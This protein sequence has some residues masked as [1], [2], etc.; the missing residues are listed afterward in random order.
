M[1][2]TS[3]IAWSQRGYRTAILRWSLG[4]FC[5]VVG[6]LMLI[7][8]HQFLGPLFATLR[9][10]LIAW[11]V[12]YFTAGSTLVA[13]VALGIRGPLP[14][15]AGVTSAAGLLLL[16]LTFLLSGGMIGVGVYSAF[17][18]TAL[19]SLWIGDGRGR[20]GERP[21]EMF[22]V[23]AAVVAL[24]VG[25]LLLVT[26][27]VWTYAA[28]MPARIFLVSYGGFFLSLGLAALIAE[29]GPP[30]A[31]AWRTPTLIALG[32][33]YLL[34]TVLSPFMARIWTGVA[35][36]GGIGWL[37]IILSWLEAALPRVVSGSL[38]VRLSL[39]MAS[40]AA[41]PLLFVATVATGWEE[42]AAAEQ[43][44]TLQ[45][46][47][48]SGLAADMSG[49]LTQHLVGLTLV[50]EHPVV[51]ERPSTSPE[52][53]LGDVEDVAPGLVTLG[54]FNRA[55]QPSAVLGVRTEEAR[56]RVQRMASEGLRRVPTRQSPSAAF[57][58]DPPDP[59]IV[60]AV[61]IRPPEGG[62]EGVA[63]GQLDRA[64]LKARLENGVAESAVG[65]VVV[66]ERGRAV[67]A[68]GGPINEDDDLS[69]RPSF[70]ALQTA[71]AA[72]GI[73]R[74]NFGAN[75]YL[76]AYARIPET[77]WAVV[78][79]QPTATA[80]ASVWSAREL[81]FVVLLGAFAAAAI[82]GVVLADRLGAPLA[83]L[84]RAAQAFAVGAPG[85]VLPTSR[86]FEVNVLARAFAEMQSR[87]TAR[88]AERER[89]QSRLRVLADAG[90]ELTRSLDEEEIVR[91]LGRVVVRELADWCTVDV[92]YAD[93]QIRSALVLHS[94]PLLQPLADQLASCPISLNHAPTVVKRAIVAGEPV[95]IPE[96]GQD[97]LTGLADGPERAV[98][99]QAL[100]L[101][102]LILV[103]LRVRE[104]TLGMLGCAIARGSRRY[105][106]DD[107]ALAQELAQRAGLAIDN[108]GLYAGEQAARAEAE[109][110]V[111]A[112]DEFL[113]VA[114]HELKTPVTSLRGFAQL[115][116]RSLNAHGRLDPAFA[117]RTLE[118]LERQSMRLASLVANLLEVARS[119]ADNVTIQP[120]QLNLAEL[121]RTV[122]EAAQIRSTLHDIQLEA[123]T[124]IEL[125]ADPLRIE[126]VV[127]NL[128]EN[129]VKY[130][131]SGSR[132]EVWVHTQA[133]DAVVVVR[134]HGM[135]IPPEHRPRIFERF[136]QA[137]A[138][139]YASGM[140]LGLYI[141]QEIVRR[142][143][144]TLRVEQ[145]DDGGTRMVLT[146][147]LVTVDTLHGD[148]STDA[149]SG[150][151]RA[152]S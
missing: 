131:P 136:Y 123:P 134:D 22:V 77:S 70:A 8:P 10:G 17:G 32:V 148:S 43:Q 98:A 108:A 137:H 34:W 66:D 115:G 67:V 138:G 15:V 139:D 57:M 2:G 85:P 20:T 142:H 1:I 91:A 127:T 149:S 28:P 61:P 76:A 90:H 113:A 18:I 38:R 51:L 63:V 42:Q 26:P 135:G 24:V 40:A 21:V 9:P 118:A 45:Q 44:L 4:A 120:E 89:A 62:I 58:L 112:R 27:P 150:G 128:L 152:A 104:R 19:I 12:V 50:A 55:G 114:A 105:D 41:F 110:A 84:A 29:L 103:P 46:A 54:I 121:V 88:T 106:A 111:R 73:L 11:G 80:L 69:N 125:L 64:W 96:V 14:I 31:R 36:Y 6:A 3:T 37:L 145:P 59:T 52:S 87:L 124:S 53:L 122:V 117:R 35:F 130:S 144:G 39:A 101:R 23:A 109:A 99:I 78:V 86:I 7:A 49:A 81:T 65:A 5:A 56:A 48:A 68:A 30:T 47:L 82:L 126:Q 129:A 116:I 133:A 132:I 151:D 107:L 119:S 33:T 79:E 83:S 93:G 143:G 140:G 72:R 95:L 13:T 60:L 74:F 71:T 75:E 92:L 102:S 25:T 146:L 141:S 94:D 147:P 97:D 16:A 100:G